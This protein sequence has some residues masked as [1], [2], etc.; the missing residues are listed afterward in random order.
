MASKKELEKRI[1]ALEAEIA[2]LK[3]NPRGTVYNIH[4]S[5]ADAALQQLKKRP[6]DP[7]PGRP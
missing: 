6:P 3:P 7:F 1:E 5:D 4:C 2:V